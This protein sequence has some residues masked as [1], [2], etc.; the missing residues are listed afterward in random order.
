[1]D[2]NSIG[3]YSG[4][5][6]NTET[7]GA[8]DVKEKNENNSYETKEN[9]SCPTESIKA[10]YAPNLVMP[11]NCRMYGADNTAKKINIAENGQEGFR[12]FNKAETL[13]N[14]VIKFA[15]KASSK[16]AT[17]RDKVE[18]FYKMISKGDE[19]SANMP[20]YSI[21]IPFEQDDDIT[22]SIQ[23]KTTGKYDKIAHLDHDGN[24]K[25]FKV[26]NSAEGTTEEYFYDGNGKLN[27]YIT[28][29]EG[30]EPFI[31][32]VNL[33]DRTLDC[34]T[35]AID[36]SGRQET[37]PYEAGKISFSDTMEPVYAEFRGKAS[38]D[39]IIKS[40]SDSEIYL[41]EQKDGH[42]ENY[43]YGVQ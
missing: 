21:N 5:N 34:K 2:I 40:S 35:Y 4:V 32:V 18:Q 23:S 42:A 8:K 12:A 27:R 16:S 25:S 7:S 41:S 43:T 3:C 22:L 36:K 15:N 19:Y 9:T 17:Q 30:K 14:D 37:S 1:M 31:K 38:G 10:F 11:K 26:L 24:I 39:K 29:Q 20:E 28:K 33:T 13:S 6:F